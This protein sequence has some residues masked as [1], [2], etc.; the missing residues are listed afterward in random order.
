MLFSDRKVKLSEDA[1]RKWKEREQRREEMKKRREEHKL[2]REKTKG[3]HVF[4]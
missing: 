3:M 2:A 4:L 1:D